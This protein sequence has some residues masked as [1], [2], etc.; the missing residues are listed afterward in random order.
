M[1]N[2]TLQTDGQN[3]SQGQLDGQDSSQKGGQDA[4]EPPLPHSQA[5][6]GSPKELDDSKTI[7]EAIS[8]GNVSRVDTQVEDAFP[9]SWDGDTRSAHMYKT[10]DITAFLGVNPK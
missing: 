5:L 7:Q 10:G 3:A 8:T 9:T 6:L 1:V 4:D 2:I